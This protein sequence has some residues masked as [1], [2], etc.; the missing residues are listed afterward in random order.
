MD[1]SN[2]NIFMNSKVIGKIPKNRAEEIKVL[3]L[4]NNMVDIRIHYYFENDP[5]PRPT[6]RGVWISFK[7]MPQVLNN[8]EELIKDKNKELNLEFEKNETEKIKVYNNEFRGN[9]LIHI[10]SFY[11]QDNEYKP[12]K[13][14]SFSMTLL[15]QV[16]EV[17]K[18]ANEYKNQ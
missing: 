6:K 5:E 11:L 1:R 2:A 16:L 15:P 17:L 7:D 9:R 12:G 18:K 14:V 13:G 10:R 8:F 3:V 4:K